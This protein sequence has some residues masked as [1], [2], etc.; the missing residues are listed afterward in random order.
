M[1]VAHVHVHTHVPFFAHDNCV[2]G[3][4]G[5]LVNPSSAIASRVFVW[6]YLECAIM[7]AWLPF[8]GL[9]YFPFQKCKETRENTI[10][11][12]QSH[13]IPKL[14]ILDGMGLR[15]ANGISPC[16]F[17]FFE[18]WSMTGHLYILL[19]FRERYMPIALKALIF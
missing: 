19:L 4:Y 1:P 18:R 10:T 3:A 9:S 11:Q 14:Y 13:P 8:H 5:I 2:Q 6:S 16:F 17:A 12:P 7:E 15:L